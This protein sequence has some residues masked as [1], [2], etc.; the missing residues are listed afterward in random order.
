MAAMPEP[1]DWLRAYAKVQRAA[2]HEIQQLLRDALRDINKTLRETSRRQGIGSAVRREQ[3]MTIKRAMQKL[4][5]ELF[6]KEG[7][8]IRARRLEAA[9]NAIK[10]NGALDAV[11]FEAAGLTREARVLLD[12][13][14]RGLEHQIEVAVARMTGVTIP[15]SERI[16]RT[17]VWMDGRVERMINSALARGLTARE[18][19]AEAADWFRPDVPGGMR[20][21]SLRLARTEINNAFHAISIENSA[22]KPWVAGMQW[23]LSSSHPKPDVCD[24][25][26]HGGTKGN[27]IYTKGDVPAKPH[28][29]CFCYITPEVIDED[30]FLDRLLAGKYDDFIDGRVPS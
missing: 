9:A 19:A 3:L 28:P 24:K 25:L 29:H 20:Y 11:L 2:D 26:A 15:L 21:A 8:I 23:H 22:Q 4:Q 27:G 30:L 7:N 16:Y 6:R 10:M 17:S 5:A 18:F 13:F 14:L 1:S 12:S